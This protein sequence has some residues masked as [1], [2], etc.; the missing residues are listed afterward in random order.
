MHKPFVLVILVTLCSVS[1]MAQSQ[2]P[3]RKLF[4]DPHRPGRLLDSSQIK[5]LQ[6]RQQ[7]TSKELARIKDSVKTLNTTTNTLLRSSHSI[8]LNSA[9]LSNS[10]GTKASFTPDNDTTLYTGQAISFT[11]TSQNADSYEWINDVYTKTTSTDFTNF[12]P[13]VG[14]TQ[15][16]LVA[17]RGDCA[18]TAVTY[19]VNNGTPP[20]DPKR[21]IVT[22]G[23]PI[24][25]EWANCITNAKTDGYLL[26]GG[27]GVSDQN[28]MIAPYFVRVSETGCILWSRTLKSY[29]ATEVQSVISTY[30]DGFVAQVL[31]GGFNDAAYL[32]KFDKNG[33]MLWAHYY[34]GPA[35]MTWNGTVREMSDHSLMVLS[36]Q[37]TS[38][39][40]LLMNVDEQGNFRWQKKY[41]MSNSGEAYFSDLVEENGSVWI[42]GNYYHLINLSQ[43]LWNTFPMLFKVDAATGN[44]QWAK[45]YTSPD[46]T[47]TWSG[48]HFYKDGLIMNG[49]ADSLVVPYNNEWSNFETLLETDLDGNIREGKLIFEPIELNSQIGDDVFVNADNS[50]S[51]FHSGVQSLN[52]Q[53]GFADRGYYLRLDANKNILWQNDY[54]GYTVGLLAHAAP[55]PAKGLAMIGQRMNSLQSPVY[56]FSENLVMVKVDSNGKGPDIQCD[57]YESF[58][59]MKD[60]PVTPYSP[61]SVIV[62]NELL[63]VADA[64]ANPVAANSEIRYNCPDYVPLCSFMKLS[65][66]NSVCNL[67]DTFDFIAHK[68][69]SCADPVT[70]TYDNVNIKTAYQ[71]GGKLRLIFKTPGVYKIRAEK[72][73][74]CA[75]IADSILVTVA[76]GLLDFNLGN[77]TTLC[78]GDSLLLKP[79]RKYNS[80]LWQDGSTKDSFM[81]KTAGDYQLT[82]T[83]SCGNTKPDMIHVDFRSS[84]ALDLGAPRTK[85]K[86]DKL[87]IVPPDGFQKYDWTPD[88]NI[89][90]SSIGGE[91]IV[92]PTQDTVYHLT[93]TDAS[94]CKGSADLTVNIYPSV[95]FSLGNDTAICAGGSA[96]FSAGTGFTTYAWSSGA[97]SSFIIANTAGEY[98][99]MVKDQNNCKLFDTVSLTVYPKP[100]IQITGGA[101]ICKDQSLILDAGSGFVSY[102][103]QDGTRARSFNVTDTGFY[104]VQVIDAHQCVA[105]DSI[106][107]QQFAESP[108]HFL[109]MDTIVCSYLGALIQPNNDF[110]QYSWSTGETGKSIQVKT[111]GEYILNVIDQQGCRGSDSIRIALKDCEALLVF[112]NAFTPNHDGHND[113]FR[114]KY[115]GHA[116]DYNLQ[117]FNRWGQKIFETSDTS[118]G[119]DG[120]LNDQLQPEGNYVWIVRYTDNSG[121]KQNMQGS[122][123]LIR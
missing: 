75:D 103:W 122:V 5:L 89:A 28:F 30:D 94:G 120:K 48:I 33:N 99:V 116:T 64:V 74:P 2:F 21:L 95:D 113:I 114:L 121:K 104:R 111:A 54:S 88:Y 66:K 50:L 58:S 62:T 77:D 112:P 59:V 115:P 109:P 10:C 11:N 53:P 107:I 91:V 51:V 20:A 96:S 67:K 106:Y 39:N 19:V 44:L 61:G 25:N 98:S 27:S 69:P 101:V 18:D 119:W 117:I 46:K 76:P 90:I 43:N 82:V 118:F 86:T 81:V 102:V 6:L 78:T 87:L 22:Y 34:E 7:F 23:L 17:H 84:I 110:L 35:A 32:V 73:F 26:A 72:P 85:C 45:G 55:T 15:I 9:S 31:V 13:A 60:M 14:V 4:P 71:D 79:K 97:S 123:V 93:V 92:F 63:Q 105:A 57:M 56:G 12:V 47:Y 38:A 16:M 8:T 68:D 108:A 36:G 1:A 70:W 80:Y 100:D 41:S 65:G 24:T 52:L 49:N 3:Q 42:A 37:Y 83:D 40:F 29:Y